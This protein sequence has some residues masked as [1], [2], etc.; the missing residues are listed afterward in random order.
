MKD[1]EL[2]PEELR[3]LRE[4]LEK[5]AQEEDDRRRVILEPTSVPATNPTGLPTA[6]AQGSSVPTP[7]N[8]AKA[9]AVVCPQCGSPDYR[10]VS[11]SASRAPHRLTYRLCSSCGQPFRPPIR[12][13]TAKAIG[14]AVLAVLLC[15]AGVQAIA[16]SVTAAIWIALFF[17]AAVA[18]MWLCI[19][20]SASNR[21]KPVATVPDD[22][23]TS[24]TD[25]ASGSRPTAAAG[26]D[27]LFASSL[28][29]S[30]P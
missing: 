21:V 25:S 17:A 23:G 24:P 2:S 20:L 3:S 8:M 4:E 27:V 6:S 13:R 7:S 11:G 14:C 22:G 10:Q 9:A 18:L 19:F 26:S 5:R 28:V 30:G 1:F 16:A 15:V 29:V 12:F